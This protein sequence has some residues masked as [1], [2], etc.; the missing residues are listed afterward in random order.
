MISRIS[1][2]WERTHNHPFAVAAGIDRSARAIT[3]AALL[4]CI[5]LGAFLASQIIVLKEIGMVQPL[6]IPILM[7]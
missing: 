7:Y 5:V 2:I 3:L 1:E 6:L 4:L